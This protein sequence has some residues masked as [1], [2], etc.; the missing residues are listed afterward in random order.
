MNKNKFIKNKASLSNAGAVSILTI[1][2]LFTIVIFAYT[3][4]GGN[5]F[6][7]TDPPPLPP[8][9]TAD[10]NQAPGAP[11][12]P[13]AACGRVSTPPGSSPG[14]SCTGLTATQPMSDGYYIPTNFGCN[15]GFPKDPSDNCI[16][17]CSGIPE[18]NGIPDGP[19]CENAIQWYAANSDQYGCNSKLLVTN[20][21][22][23]KAVVVRAVDRGPSCSVQG[24]RGKF[25]LSQAAYA[26]INA[27]SMVKIE[28]VAESVPLGPVGMCP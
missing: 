25:D 21:T 8:T 9:P 16:P 6:K 14:F 28:K 5:L 22:T 12:V 10:P 13:G 2:V 18:C 17:A 20:P 19:A 15:T 11:G 1:L 27:G 24:A 23:G 3:L 26:N 4:V 7:P